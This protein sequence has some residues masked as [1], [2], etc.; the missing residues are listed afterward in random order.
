MSKHELLVRYIIDV[1]V[2]GCI[3]I[4]WVVGRYGK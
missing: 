4:H 3:K 1:W 2:V